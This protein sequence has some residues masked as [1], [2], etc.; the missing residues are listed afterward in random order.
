MTTSIDPALVARLS[1]EFTS[2]AG[3]FTTLG[4]QLSTLGRDL[5]ALHRQVRTA[6][7]QQSEPGTAGAS[8]PTAEQGPGTAK[9]AAPQSPS[10]A[11]DRKSVV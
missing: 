10:P 7:P 11:A 8:A 9:P 2:I 5:E 3:G 6:T 1:G 4:G